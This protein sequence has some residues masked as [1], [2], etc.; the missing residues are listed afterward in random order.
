MYVSLLFVIDLLQLSAISSIF[1]LPIGSSTHDWGTVGL[2]ESQTS[3]T[4]MFHI[5]TNN[6]VTVFTTPLFSSGE[7]PKKRPDDW[8]WQNVAPGQGF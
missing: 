7:A 1:S 5:N 3:Q 2:I 6:F 4:L 8:L